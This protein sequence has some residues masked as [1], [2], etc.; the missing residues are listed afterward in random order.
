MAP[1]PWIIL[2]ALLLGVGL[3]LIYGAYRRWSWL[4]DP[5]DYLWPVYS[6]AFLKKLFGR[7]VVIGWTYLF[8]ILL[9]GAMLLSL[10]K[11]LAGTCRSPKT[12]ALA[13]TAL[14]TERNQERHDLLGGMERTDANVSAKQ[15][16]LREWWGVTDKASLLATLRWID[17][18]GHRERF[19]NVAR[20]VATLSPEELGKVRDTLKD[21]AQARQELEVV[22]AHHAK[23][24]EKSLLGW[25]YSRYVTL[26]RW[27]YLVGYLTED[28][29]W[30]LIMPGAR[31]LQTTFDSWKDLGENYLIGREFWS[32]AETE[33]NGLLYQQV[34]QRLLDDP[35][36]PWNQ[37]AWDLNLKGKGGASTTPLS[38]AGIMTRE[39]VDQ[40]VTSGEFGSATM[41]VALSREQ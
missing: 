27:G 13:T 40:P 22:L 39:T 9:V 6:Q 8:G 2:W 29:A 33:R 7:R 18:E 5:P 37:C 24:G 38:A 15:Q 28:E 35:A 20:Y 3:A 30:D 36:S 23:L 21:N 19:E 26:C 16:L 31:K 1:L 25:D 10:W 32:Q 12:W 17:G 14:L 11:G 41:C 4:I 34:Y